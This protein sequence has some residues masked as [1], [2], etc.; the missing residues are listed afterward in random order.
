MTKTVI[1][2][3]SIS[4][5]YRLGV[6]NHG[7]LR[8]D[9]QSWWAHKRGLPDPNLEIGKAGAKAGTAFRALE[10]VSFELVDVI[11]VHER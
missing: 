10:D 2:V 4:K 8:R 1:S 11:F 7:T 6:T 3:Q 9:L 5:D